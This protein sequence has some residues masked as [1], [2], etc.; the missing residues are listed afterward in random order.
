MSLTQSIRKMGEVGSGII[1]GL[2]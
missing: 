1:R 2:L